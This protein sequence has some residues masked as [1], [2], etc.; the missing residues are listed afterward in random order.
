[1]S[2]VAN[3]CEM[4]S[5]IYCTKRLSLDKKSDSVS[6]EVLLFNICG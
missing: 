5:S 4:F 1:M 2:I 3:S 6:Q